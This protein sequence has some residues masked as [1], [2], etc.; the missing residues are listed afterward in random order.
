MARLARPQ[1]RGARG[2]GGVV[3]RGVRGSRG[4]A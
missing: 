1:W 4:A 3:W 2:S